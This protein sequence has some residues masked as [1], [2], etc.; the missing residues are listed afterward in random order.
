MSRSQALIV[1][2]ARFG[3]SR[4]RGKALRRLCGET[5]LARCLQ[6]LL[7]S[8]VGPVLLATTRRRE[9]DALVREAARFGVTSLRG[10]SDDVLGRFA[11]AVDLVRP[12]YVIRATGDNPAVDV[13]APARV[14]GA[15]ESRP[16]DYAVEDGLPYGAA[17]EGVRAAALLDAAARTSDPYDREHVTPFLRR[18]GAGYRV[19]VT[20]AP[21]A[22]RRPDLRFTVDT[23]EDFAWMER[24]FTRAGAQAPVL[25]LADIIRAADG[26][27]LPEVA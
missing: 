10:P 17:V 19:Q 1:L 2:Q 5:L 8:G 18:P 14:L 22:V 27:R 6:R 12:E 16:L 25:P 26:L 15:L 20:E 9:D 13:E 3:S 7:A 4:L 24:V 23:L 21:T 11:L